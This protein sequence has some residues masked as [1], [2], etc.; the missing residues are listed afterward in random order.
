MPNDA[1]TERRVC[2]TNVTKQINKVKQRKAENR[3]DLL[4][5]EIDEL[6][7][8]FETF[9][10]AHDRYHGELETDEDLDES[11][12][13]FSDAQAVYINFLDET[14]S[15]FPQEEAP[16]VKAASVKGN[17]ETKLLN[18]LSLPKIELDKF[19]GNPLY[20]HSFFATFNETVD[21]VADDD[22][23]KLTRLIQYTTGDAHN[24]I[25]SCV[26]MEGSVGYKHAREILRERFGN[27][28]LVTERLINSLKDGKTVRGPE[29]LQLFCDE[30]CNC[31]MTLSQMGKLQEVQSQGY[32]LQIVNRLQQYLRNRWKKRA[33]DI[34]RD[35]DRYPRFEEFVEFVKEQ[36]LEATDPVYGKPPSSGEKDTSKGKKA[37]SFASSSGNKVERSAFV[38]TCI[39]CGDAH[40]LLYCAQFKTMKLADRLKFVN[41]RKLCE[42]CLLGNHV[43]ANCRKNTVCTVEGCGKR[44]TRLIHVNNDL[45]KSSNNELGTNVRLLNANVNVNSDIHMPVVPVRVNGYCDTCALLDTASSNTFCTTDLL[46]ALKVQ[47]TPVTYSLSTLNASE[48]VQSKVVNLSLTSLDG[49]EKLEL[50]NVYVVDNIPFKTTCPKPGAYPHL[51]GL[52]LVEGGQDVHLLLGQDNAEALLPL[53]VKQG[54]KGEPFACRTLFGWSVNG[55]CRV[56]GPVNQTVISHFISTNSLE[57]KVQNLW[58]MENEGV[59]D[60]GTAWSQEDKRVVEL[61][62]KECHLVSGHY[63]IPIPWKPGVEVP[64]NFIMAMSRLKSLKSSLIK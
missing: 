59:N 8:K 63:E 28:H 48:D 31:N 27:N 24:A 49:S 30:V 44:H 36:T 40:R 58:H 34:K 39:L 14:K 29:E 19:D 64:N 9:E 41:S 7:K 37:S 55:P 38:H 15:W 45:K 1:K 5:A 54:A 33:L 61:W 18:A 12:K 4:K 60:S 53:D 16:A 23:I 51:K 3:K 6:I 10:S 13:Y 57:E 43:T 11:D 56:D 21:K 26:L 17:S 50:G 22:M 42:N 62:D 35:K 2:K 46:H 52:T 25:L 32:I 47:G 20:Y